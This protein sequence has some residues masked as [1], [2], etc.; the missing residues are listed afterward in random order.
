MK[1]FFKRGNGLIFA[2]LFLCMSTGAVMA[3]TPTNPVYRISSAASPGTE[4]NKTF[5]AFDSQ[6]TLFYFDIRDIAT[7]GH[8][9]KET[10]GQEQSIDLLPVIKSVLPTAL[11]PH[12]TLS[13][14]LCAIQIDNQDRIFIIY[15]AFDPFG[16]GKRKWKGRVPILLYS[17]DKGATFKAA[18]LPGSPDEAFLEER[19]RVTGS[20]WPPLIGWTTSTHVKISELGD[21]NRFGIIIPQFSGN[22]LELSKVY[23]VAENNPGVSNHTG[24]VSFACTVSDVSYFT[25][26]EFPEDKLGNNIMVAKLD[27]NSNE[28]VEKSM[29]T[30]IRKP[31]FPD[32]HVSPVIVTTKN[33]ILHLITGSK[34]GPFGHFSADASESTLTWHKVTDLPGARVYANLLIDNEDNLH[35]LYMEWSHAP[36]L[37][38]QEFSAQS[39]QW[40]EEKTLLATPDEFPSRTKDNY[41][42]YYYKG[43]FDQNFN[44]YVSFSFWETYDSHLYPRQVLVKKQDSN[45]WSLLGN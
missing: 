5:M 12:D 8:L 9:V 34:G 4:D 32:P 38:Y 13:H 26:N 17:F 22:S 39:Q 2:F 21:I 1:K 41:G 29:V 31:N 44:F 11:I 7:Y 19:N 36:R 23:T 40:G 6:N 20:K 45:D 27:R 28:I 33:G 16:E 3:Q 15:Y 42:I 24:G 10:N 30:Q 18:L 35:L 37:C 43:S 14:A 25:Y